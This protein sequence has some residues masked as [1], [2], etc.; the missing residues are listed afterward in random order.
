MGDAGFTPFF[1]PEF[2]WLVIVVALAAI[3][4]E[5]GGAPER[6]IR[7][8][9]KAHAPFRVLQGLR[10]GFGISV[11]GMGWGLLHESRVITDVALIAAAVFLTPM[12]IIQR[13]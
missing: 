5:I 11:A 8:H 7:R 13:R 1:F 9:L 3:L 6:S 12:V 10:V 2:G 4:A